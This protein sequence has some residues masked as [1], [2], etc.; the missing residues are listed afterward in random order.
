VFDN[1]AMIYEHWRRRPGK[2]AEAGGD[3]V[4]TETLSAAK[5]GGLGARERRLVEIARAVVGRPRVVL[6]T[7]RRP[8]CPRKRPSICAA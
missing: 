8:A 7:S 1:V 4:G 6:S 5:V 3:P 2:R